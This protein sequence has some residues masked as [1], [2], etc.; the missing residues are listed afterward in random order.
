MFM[1][2]LSPFDVLSGPLDLS[3]FSSS[4]FSVMIYFE[5]LAGMLGIFL[6]MPWLAP[7]I[8]I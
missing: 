1:F 5:V 3:L 4:L 7:W 8:L 2:L 6:C